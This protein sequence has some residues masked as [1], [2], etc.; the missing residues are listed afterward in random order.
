M[1]LELKMIVGNMKVM[2][3]VAMVL[4]VTMTQLAQ[5]LVDRGDGCVRAAGRAVPLQQQ[6]DTHNIGVVI[7]AVHAHY[8]P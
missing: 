3:M 2:A 1:K 7:C 5:L 6:R 8:W 4:M